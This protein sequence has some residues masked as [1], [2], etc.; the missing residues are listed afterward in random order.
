MGGGAQMKRH[1]CGGGAQ[2][3]R[4]MCSVGEGLMKRYMEVRYECSY[5]GGAMCRW[6]EQVVHH[7]AMC[8]G[9]G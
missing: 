4:Y 1:M 6:R 5:E 9:G 7:Y 3:K 8:E 2:M